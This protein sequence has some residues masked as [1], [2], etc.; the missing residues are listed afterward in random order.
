ML[1]LDFANNTVKPK[2]EERS[3]KKKKCQFCAETLVTNYAYY[4]HANKKHKTDVSKD[5]HLCELCQLFFPT[6]NALAHHRR[7]AHSIFLDRYVFR[8]TH[9][10]GVCPDLN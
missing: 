2:M 1:S 6:T 4:K 9:R 7:A 8:P 10:V 3:E 5:W